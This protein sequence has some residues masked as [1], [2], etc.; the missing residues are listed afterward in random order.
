MCVPL[1]PPELKG[2]LQGF[3]LRVWVSF[4]MEPEPGIEGLWG[5]GGFHGVDR[6]AQKKSSSGFRA[7]GL[8]LGVSGSGFRV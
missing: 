5:L 6:N 1:L 7:Q 3:G 4:V 8:E 2:I